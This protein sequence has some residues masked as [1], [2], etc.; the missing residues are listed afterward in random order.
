[1]IDDGG[2]GGSSFTSMKV[3][4]DGIVS[5]VSHVLFSVRSK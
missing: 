5:T 4:D 3:G 2:R 1:M